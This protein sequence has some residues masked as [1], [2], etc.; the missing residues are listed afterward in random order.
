MPKPQRKQ[1]KFWPRVREL[2]WEKAQELY[3]TE[4]AKTM[5]KDFK[6]ITA[7]RKELREGGYFYLAKLTVLR[8]L[9]RERKGF[10]TLEEEEAQL[11]QEQTATKNSLLPFKN[12]RFL[13][14]K[15][16]EGE[17]KNA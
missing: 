9:W 1:G 5:G 13:N 16:K 2:I 12:R 8:N 10:P 11:F 6:G 7:T 14:S 4:Q 15:C 17:K 3:Q